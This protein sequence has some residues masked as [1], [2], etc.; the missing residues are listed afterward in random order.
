[1]QLREELRDKPSDLKKEE[2]LQDATFHCEC[3][4]GCS[5]EGKQPSDNKPHICARDSSI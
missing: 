1:M 4:E 3:A 5:T 2:K